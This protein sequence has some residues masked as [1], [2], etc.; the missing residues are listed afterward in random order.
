M[1][2]E[3]EVASKASHSDIVE[4]PD[5]REF[6]AE[7]DYVREPTAEEVERFRKCFQPVPQTWETGLPSHIFAIDGSPYESQ[8][9]DRLP[10]TRVG[11]IKVSTI[12]ISLDEFG[13]L[14]VEDGRFVDPF[15]VAKLRRNKDSLLFVVPGSNMKWKGYESVRD[16]FRARVDHELLKKE[17]RFNKEDHKTSLRSTL[18]HLAA[19]RPDKMGTGDPNRIRLHQCPSCKHPDLELQDIM[20][21][22]YCLGRSFRFSVKRCGDDTLHVGNRAYVACALPAPF[23]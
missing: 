11:Y 13:A 16:S 2:Y 8:I 23:T 1:P 12:C 15:R 9:D 5:V 17:T 18:F 19:A 21:T 4:N 20:E 6:L 22:Q 3:N 14:R 10:N 7:S